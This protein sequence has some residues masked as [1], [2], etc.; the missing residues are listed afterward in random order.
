[1]AY[2]F[3]KLTG[4]IKETEEWLTR[5]LAGIRTGRATPA[6]LDSV[7]ADA[8]GTRTPL[9]GLASITVEDARTI[10]LIPWDKTVSKSIEKA[11]NDADLGVSVS[12]DDTGL[13]VIFPELTAERR[14]MLQ[15]LVGD[16]LEQARVT[17]RGHRAD[18]LKELDAAEKEGG[19]GQDELKRLKEEAQKHI[20]KGMEALD[21]LARKKQE[22][23]AQ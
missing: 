11:V 8:Y 4:H 19:M 18:A 15:K 23:I 10:R 1:M 22:D 3:S 6:L 7:K 9:T 5:E 13:R 12:V 14:T 16:R 21:A 2:D 20:D 17:L